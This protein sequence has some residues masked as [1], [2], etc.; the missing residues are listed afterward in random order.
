MSRS[1]ETLTSRSGLRAEITESGSLRRLDCGPICLSLFIGNEVESGPANLFLRRRSGAPEWTPLL[2]PLSPTRWASPSAGGRLLGRGTWRGIEY[3]LSL[4]LAQDAPA[5]FWHLR[6]TNAS[7]EAL[8]LD[9]TYAQDLALA[10]YGAVRMNEYYVSQYID[11]TPLA[12]ADRGILIAS[13]QNQAAAGRN[14]WCLIGSLRN[15]TSFATDALDFH[16]LAGRSG[17]AP[18]GILGELPGRRLQHEHSM[19]VL[20]DAA[21]PL[22]CGESAEAGFFGA[23]VPDHP[24]A[25]TDADLARLASILTLPEASPAAASGEPAFPPVTRAGARS[26]FSSS[27][28]LRATELDAS[29]LEQ[30]FPLPWR[31]EETDEGGERL[32]FFHGRDRHVALRAKELRVLR[33]HGQLLRTGRHLTPDESALTSTVWMSGVFH[34]M[35]TQGHV[36]INRFLSASHSY[37]GLFHSHGLTV[38]ARIAD[39]WR[40]LGVPSAFEMAPES[41]RWIYRHAQGEIQLRAAARSVPHA[42]AL[43]IEVTAGAATAFLLCHHIALAGDDGSAPGALDWRR[44]G[45]ALIVRAPPASDVGRRFPQGDFRITLAA[46]TPLERLGGD[47]LLFSDGR[48][49]AEP[50]LCVQTAPARKVGLSIGGGLIAEASQKPWCPP[51]GEPPPLPQ[52]LPD[53]VTAGGAAA[54]ERARRQVREQATALADMAP[55]YAQNALVHYLSPRGLEQYSGGG[56]GTRDVCQGPVEMLLALG[57]TEPVRDVLLRVMA[58]QNPDGD[59]PQWFMFFERE[60]GIRAG[61]SHGDI[62]FWPLVAL[63][64]YLIA[65]GDGEIL[66]AQVPFFDAKGP[67]SAERASVWQHIERA[68]RLIERRR[69]AGTALAAYGHGDWNDSL[70][71][72]DPALREHMC[73]AWTVTLHF[74]ALTSLARA[75]RGLGRD[76]AAMPLEEQASA[77]RR[78]FQRL[79]LPD[80]VLTGYA[81]FDGDSQIRYLLHPRDATTGVRYSSLAMIHAILEDMLTPAQTQAHL[82]L[83]GQHLTGPDGVRLFDRPLPYH[84]G[85]QRIFQRA[86][87][88]TFFGREIGL[89]YMHAHL[90][91]AQALAHVGLAGEFFHALCQANPIG[92][93][94]I[95]PA[96]TLRQAN[97][98][99]SSSDAAFL[100]RY[101]AREEYGRIRD[102]RIALDGGWRVYSSGAGIALGLILRRFLGFTCEADA[103]CIDPVMPQVLDGMRLTLCLRGH[104]LEVTYRIGPAGCGVN[105]VLL[106]GRTLPLAPLAREANPHRR[107]AVRA[108]MAAV[109]ERLEPRGNRLAIDLG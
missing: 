22:G 93:R 63:G 15:A 102:G 26:L 97:C 13:R 80:G 62:V 32:S 83:I 48:S 107:G 8:E 56:W 99:Y 77:V 79:L 49:R 11:H 109:L 14:P 91:Y 16:G 31:H 24:D 81:I 10:P 37:L 51:A 29:A 92:I 9:L 68:L 104:P 38:F 60:R 43:E 74:Q 75:L 7:A 1:A 88:A 6:L 96:A 85:P 44:E 66:E 3:A 95:V 86:E 108:P 90:R 46:E 65:S 76:S 98:Y 30:L 34:S 41:C 105:E 53:P 54:P 67:G 64:Q 69:I 39:E 101:Q 17:E 59:W 71:P 55:W 23:V 73:S 5:W 20:R 106:N 94:A 25:T 40:R 58:T 52:L 89:M 18:P 84:G 21:L 82:E 33:P 50:Y 57:R 42:M 28:A 27:P 70:Q 4:V 12:H 72:A 78:D 61:D 19:A 87:S 103:L 100:D 36:S 35:L 2:G 45:D 47:E